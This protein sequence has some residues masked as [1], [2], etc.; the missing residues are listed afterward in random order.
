MPGRP[1]AN[2]VRFSFRAV[3]TDQNGVSMAGAADAVQRRL[4]GSR[5]RWGWSLPKQAGCGEP[6]R[7]KGGSPARACRACEPPRQGVLAVSH[8]FE[9]GRWILAPSKS[10]LQPCRLTVIP[11]H[12]L[13]FSSASSRRICWATPAP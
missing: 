10:L 2:R 12:V 6:W 9:G 8:H 5:V 7:H 4:K 13:V 1:L 11:Q 3:T